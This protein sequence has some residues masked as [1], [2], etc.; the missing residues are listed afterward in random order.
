MLSL[1]VFSSTFE[2]SLFIENNKHSMISKLSITKDNV[3]ILYNPLVIP[4]ANGTK[5]DFKAE[6]HELSFK[7][8]I[9]G[10]EGQ[11]IE[12]AND[13]DQSNFKIT[14]MKLKSEFVAEVYENDVAMNEIKVHL[15]RCVPK[16]K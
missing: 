13:A 8:L 2:C 5:L 9:K 14:I 11:F 15:G 1:Q 12:T 3:V 6:G 7:K 10:F 16:S 4:P